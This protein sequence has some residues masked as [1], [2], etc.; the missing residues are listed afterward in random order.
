M[1][2]AVAALPLFHHATALLVRR[3]DAG[4]S[5]A[6][7]KAGALGTQGAIVRIIVQ[8]TKPR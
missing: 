1:N 3:W 7:Q 4:C 6:D 5:P 8:R 2:S